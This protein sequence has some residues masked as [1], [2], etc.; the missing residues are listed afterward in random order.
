MWADSP[1]HR[2]NLLD[3]QAKSVGIGVAKDKDGKLFA[4][5]NFGR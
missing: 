4:V 1:G 2:K 5:Q 3:P